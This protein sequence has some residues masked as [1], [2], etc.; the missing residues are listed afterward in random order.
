MRGDTKI[1]GIV[2]NADTTQYLAE[3]KYRLYTANAAISVGMQVSLATGDTTG[4]KIVKTPTTTT[5]DH[6]AIGVYEGIGGTGADA[7]LSGLTGKA[8]VTND[9]VQITVLGP[10]VALADLNAQWTD[11]DVLVASTTTAGYLS[12]GGATLTA[13]IRPL[14]IAK[15]AAVTSTFTNLA[16][17]VYVFG[18]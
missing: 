1:N 4:K 13:G 8:A 15:E 6:V 9:L 2:S 17:A 11:H 12:S 18:S 5:T 10:V 14:A 16:K 7:T 3:K